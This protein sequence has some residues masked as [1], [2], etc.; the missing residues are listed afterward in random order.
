MKGVLDNTWLPGPHEMVHCI[1]TL[2]ML[3]LI[4]ILI[5][6]WLSNTSR[7]GGKDHLSINKCFFLE[8][9]I[10]ASCECHSPTLSRIKVTHHIDLREQNV[11]FQQ[12]KLQ[13]QL[14]RTSSRNH[15]CS[16]GRCK[17]QDLTFVPLSSTEHKH[18]ETQQIDF[19]SYST[20]FSSTLSHKFSAPGKES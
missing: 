13:Q 7:H 2:K 3:Q 15:K 10:L 8:M 5:N 6:Y 18:S 19:T 9:V 14:F 4:I 20:N 11:I 17:T 16:Q 12:W 1:N